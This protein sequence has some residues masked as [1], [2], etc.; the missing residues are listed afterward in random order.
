MR[1]V[2]RRAG[3]RVR[4]PPNA[5]KSK[6]GM[7]IPDKSPAAHA[8][9]SAD[10]VKGGGGEA[11]RSSVHVLKPPLF[12]GVGHRCDLGRRVACDL[13]KAAE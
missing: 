4:M 1:V 6:R 2:S 13:V 12:Q 7:R 10:E 5:R 11:H 9:R 8:Y 3:G